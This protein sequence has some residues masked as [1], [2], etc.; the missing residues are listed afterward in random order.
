MKNKKWKAFEKLVGKC[1]ENMI[2]AEQDGAAGR[3]H[4]SF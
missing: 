2:G 4:L 3:M 1:Y